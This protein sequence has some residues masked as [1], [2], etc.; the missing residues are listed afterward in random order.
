VL[1]LICVAALAALR[2]HWIVAAG[3]A[4]AA[5]LAR[6]EGLFVA[7]PLAAIAWERRRTLDPA[8][9]GLAL[10]AVL[11]PAA[12]L[13]AYPL[14]LARVL[15]DPLAW[16]RAEQ[17]WG[18][19]FA[20]LGF[21]KAVTTLPAEVSQNTWVVR[22]VVFLV[23]YLAL[24]VVAWRSGVPRAWLL[25]ALGIVV[26]PVFSA[27][28]ASIGRFGLLAPPL[29]W[30]LAEL[31]RSRR[32]DHAIVGVSLVLLVTATATVPFMFP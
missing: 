9:R 16:S 23:L 11:A 18:R 7:L 5:A 20:P 17:A 4:A 28:F 29:F 15:H 2:G 26:L 24:L 21:V 19:R 6:P 30:G 10:G 25:A 22:D 13:A 14:Y 1:A 12:G 8:G 27:S 31:G 32:A 3:C